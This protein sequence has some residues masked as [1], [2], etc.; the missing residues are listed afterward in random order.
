LILDFSAVISANAA[1]YTVVQKSWRS[2]FGR[3]L[4]GKER[5]Q[6]ALRSVQE[7]TDELERLAIPVA[8]FVHLSI[9][10]L[11]NLGAGVSVQDR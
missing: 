5:F 2:R 7:S 10:K 3:V 4:I 8:D 9:I 11:K 6:V 1:E